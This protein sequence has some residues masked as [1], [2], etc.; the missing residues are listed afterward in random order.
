METCRVLWDAGL[1]A[2]MV[3]LA[4]PSQQD[5]Y[6]HAKR[7]GIRW[8]VTVEEQA[9][10]ASKVVSLRSTDNSRWV[11][12]ERASLRSRDESGCVCVAC[13]VIVGKCAQCGGAVASF[14][15]RYWN[16]VTRRKVAEETVSLDQ[17]EKRLWEHLG[18]KHR[19]E[20][21]GSLYG[22]AS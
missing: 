14:V 4:N 22:L 9:F 10:Q 2:E 8:L 13:A 20:V 18:R 6:E 1:R 5:N 11:G 15:S 7:R 12:G 21:Q 17:L 16:V 19:R 3:G